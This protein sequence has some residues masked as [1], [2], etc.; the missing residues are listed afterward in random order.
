LYTI[1]IALLIV[2]G[3]ALI[4]IDS[5]QGALGG[6]L[7]YSAVVFVLALFGSTSLIFAYSLRPRTLQ[8]K[9]LQVEPS[10]P[11]DTSPAV[12]YFNDLT[13][14]KGIGKRRAAQLKALGVD[15]VASLSTCSPE[16]LAEKLD[17]SP[18]RTTRWIAEA[19]K[20]LLEPDRGQART[21]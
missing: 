2:A 9:P 14:V 4:N 16:D 21:L 11:V 7:I 1:G 5:L 17:V 6:R 8:Q 15:T 12:E 20:H 18:K 3:Y 10:P 19:R 13:Q